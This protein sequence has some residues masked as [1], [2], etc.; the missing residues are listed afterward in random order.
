MRQALEQLIT[1]NLQHIDLSDVKIDFTTV[2]FLLYSLDKAQTLV[3]LHLPLSSEIRTA[4]KAILGNLLFDHMT[5]LD[6][7]GDIP[8]NWF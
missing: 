2:E 1:S 3:S 7:P 6:P 8:E 5:R 4:A